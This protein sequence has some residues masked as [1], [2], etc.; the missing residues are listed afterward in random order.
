MPY[1]LYSHLFNI[2]FFSFFIF[3]LLYKRE[4]VPKKKKYKITHHLCQSLIQASNKIESYPVFENVAIANDLGIPLS[5]ICL[6]SKLLL[7]PCSVCS[8]I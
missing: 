8:G 5:F 4:C 1:I 7:V 2:V 6:C 3:F